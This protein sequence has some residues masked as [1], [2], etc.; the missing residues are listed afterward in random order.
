MPIIVYNF[1]KLT[2]SNSQTDEKASVISPS[3]IVKEHLGTYWAPPQP[4][5]TNSTTP[6][7]LLSTST[8]TGASTTDVTDACINDKHGKNLNVVC[9][10]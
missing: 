1:R 9:S 6:P 10:C 8:V 4:L 7:N 2:D 5:T 3:S